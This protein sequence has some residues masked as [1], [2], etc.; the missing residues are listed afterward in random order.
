MQGSTSLDG[1]YKLLS[2]NV[3][4]CE[5]TTPKQIY[6]KNPDGSFDTTTYQSS[7]MYLI[8]NSSENRWA[9]QTGIDSYAQLMAESE[10]EYPWQTTYGINM[11]LATI[12]PPI[13]LN[14]NDGIPSIKVSNGSYQ[15]NY[16][17]ETVTDFNGTYK[18]I[19][20][21]ATG[22]NRI[23]KH[24]SKNYWIFYAYKY[25][26]NQWRFATSQPT[27]YASTAGDFLIAS[28]TAE[29]P[30]Q[31]PKS[32]WYYNSMNVNTSNSVIPDIQQG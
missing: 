1:V 5:S 25:D 9:F 13:V 26:E 4:E 23:W 22:F 3:Y 24:E 29:Q 32:S 10:A 20:K 19:D 30:Y 18:L 6:Y 27:D 2:G 12:M 14:Y 7:T 16:A 28:S 8:K 21:T 15:S 11:A 31:V 17:S